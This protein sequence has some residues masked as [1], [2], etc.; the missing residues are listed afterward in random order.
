[1]PTRASHNV[2]LYKKKFYQSVI[3]ILTNWK[4]SNKLISHYIRW[5]NDKTYYHVVYSLRFYIVIINYT[6]V[7][8]VIRKLTAWLISFLY[9]VSLQSWRETRYSCIGANFLFFAYVLLRTC[10]SLQFL[11]S[12]VKPKICR[13]A[14][15]ISPIRFAK[16][17]K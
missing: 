3:G 1:M 9:H 2:I 14:L 7:T 15:S 11:N 8:I 12:E 13:C 5:L 10:T 6:V 17:L 4:E 16:Y